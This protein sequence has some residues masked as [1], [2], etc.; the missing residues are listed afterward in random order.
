MNTLGCRKLEGASQFFRIVVLAA[1]FPA[2]FLAKTRLFEKRNGKKIFI[3]FDS[4]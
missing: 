3:L 2:I 4:L 1:S